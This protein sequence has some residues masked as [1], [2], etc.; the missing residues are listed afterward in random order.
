MAF[1]MENAFEGFQEDL[2]IFQVPPVQTGRKY[3]YTKDYTPTGVLSGSSVLEFDVQNTSPDYIRL[4]KTRLSLKLKILDDRGKPITSVDTVGLINLPSSTIFRQMDLSLQQTVVTTSIGPNFGYK[5]LIDVLMEYG[6]NDQLGWLSIAGYEKDSSGMMD[7]C[8]NDGNEGLDKRREKTAN[9][10]E[11]S[12]RTSLFMDIAKQDRLIP[13][14][15]P[16]NIKL[17]P[18]T[19]KF[20]LMYKSLSAKFNH[21]DDNCQL[22]DDSGTGTA[23]PPVASRTSKTYS[24]QITSAILTVTY[25]KLHEGLLVLQDKMFLQKPAVYPFIRSDIKTFNIPSNTYTWTRDN[26]FQNK[27]PKRLVIGMVS[28][29]SY[30]GFHEKNPFNFQHF[31]VGELVLTVDGLNSPGLAV[32]TNF[33]KKHFDHAYST[34]FECMPPD[35]KEAPA[36]SPN[37]YLRGYTLFVADLS[38][39]KGEGFTN[40]VHHGSSRLTLRF[41]KATPEGITLICY[42][43]FEA[44][45]NIDAARNVILNT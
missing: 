16:L 17:F 19:D 29:D 9:G 31:N 30:S 20:R 12:V 2:D 11:M 41:D 10:E 39:S 18:H 36:I 40:L 15:T 27:L 43:S 33:E 34:L 4:N 35:Q 32:K 45:L 42:G 21:D 25:T 24:L 3:D 37:D 22:E 23:V 44:F 38:P 5:S 7:D 14:K 6:V 26:I 1:V 13:N 28:A 8:E